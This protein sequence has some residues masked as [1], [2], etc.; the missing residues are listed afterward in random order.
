[1]LKGV[2]EGNLNEKNVVFDER[3][4]VT[5]M[6]VSGGYPE[7]YEKGKIISGVETVSDSIVFH[8]G[9]TLKGGNLVSSGGRVLA[10]SSYGKDKNEALE[11]SFMNAQKISFE[12]HYFRKDIGFDL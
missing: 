4:A 2:A 8:A 10:I 11:K 5:V 3:S 9:T 6:M 12:K 7:A 1:L